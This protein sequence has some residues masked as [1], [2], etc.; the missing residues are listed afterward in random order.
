MN[1]VPWELSEPVLPRRLIRFFA[2]L[3]NL[4]I[5]FE[6]FLLSAFLEL[7]EYEPCSEL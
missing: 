5:L 3:K 6:G 1:S 4:L 2:E 7:S